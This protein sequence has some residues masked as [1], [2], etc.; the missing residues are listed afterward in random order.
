MLSTTDE[1]TERDFDMTE[2]TILRITRT[3]HTEER[4]NFENT[5]DRTYNIGDQDDDAHNSGDAFLSLL[6][7]CCFIFSFGIHGQKNGFE[8]DDKVQ[9]MLVE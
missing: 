8:R 6:I 4:T 9:L 2:P 5:K 7:D 1:T 3:F